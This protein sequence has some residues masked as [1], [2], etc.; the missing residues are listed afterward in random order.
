MKHIVTCLLLL[1]SIAHSHEP[2]N[3]AART[4]Q[5]RFKL[6]VMPRDAAAHVE[7]RGEKLTTSAK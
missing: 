7:Y 4:V 6:R 2:A 5:R 1:T 3:D